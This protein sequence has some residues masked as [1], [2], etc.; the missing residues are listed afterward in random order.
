MIALAVSVL[1]AIAAI[2]AIVSITR[3]RIEQLHAAGLLISDFCDALEDLSKDGR[4]SPVVMKFLFS[5]APHINDTRLAKK[6]GRHFAGVEKLKSQ[7]PNGDSLELKREI[8]RLN[9]HDRLRFI[10][11]M[12]LFLAA[13]SFR[14]PLYGRHVRAVLM[15]RK[16]QAAV[17]KESTEL[18]R[19]VPMSNDGNTRVDGNLCPA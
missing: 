9:H 14:D 11:V 16:R 10:E 5:I 3:A 13:L 19:I 18:A 7:R 12:G 2:T 15:G 17:A 8:D 4:F 6:V 1:G